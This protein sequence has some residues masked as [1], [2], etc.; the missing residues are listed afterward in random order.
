MSPNKKTLGIILVSFVWPGWSWAKR[1]NE[2][3]AAMFHT[4]L[5][6]KKRKKSNTRLH[7]DGSVVLVIFLGTAIL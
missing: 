6:K 1:V 7:T 4:E 5:C 2:E 3:S